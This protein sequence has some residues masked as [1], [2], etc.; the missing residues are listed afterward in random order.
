MEESRQ[1]SQ[2]CVAGVDES[3]VVLGRRLTATIASDLRNTDPS[4][5]RS[6]GWRQGTRRLA[7]CKGE[8]ATAAPAKNRLAG[9]GNALASLTGA[10]VH[11][12]RRHD[13]LGASAKTNALS[14]FFFA[15]DISEISSRSTHPKRVPEHLPFAK[16]QLLFAFD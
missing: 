10:I 16:A 1:P 2:L 7:C 4:A 12:W 13:S 14:H 9:S 3:G 15:T 11:H 5:R 6:Q 8:T